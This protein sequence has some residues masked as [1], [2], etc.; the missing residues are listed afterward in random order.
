MRIVCRCFLVD[1]DNLTRGGRLLYRCGSVC[2]VIILCILVWCVGVTSS[3]MGLEQW[4]MLLHLF[5]VPFRICY[6]F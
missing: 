1:I 2:V 5:I 6:L 3:G 4:H